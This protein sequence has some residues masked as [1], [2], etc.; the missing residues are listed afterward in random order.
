LL[1]AP[2]SRVSGGGAGGGGRLP[3]VEIV[4]LAR[5]L[6][7]GNRGIFSRALEAA[8][9][10][11]LDRGEQAMLFL[12]RRGS[13][14]FVLCRDC[15]HVPVCS[16]CQ[17]PYTVHQA[18]ERL[19]CHQC[20]RQRRMPGVCPLCGGARLRFFGLGTQR[21]EAEARTRFPS[22]RVAR[23]DRDAVRSAADH[24]EILDALARGEV[25]VVVGTQMLAKGHDLPNV[26]LVGVVSADI[27]LHM[28]D[29][30]SG[31]RAFQLLTQVA[32]RAGRGER[33]GRVVV[34]TYT[35]D[36]YAIRAAATHD[37]RAMFDAEM[38]VRR[39]AGY[40]PFGRLAR[41]L[42][43]HTNAAAAEE[44]AHRLATELRGLR[45]QRGLPGEAVIG[46]APAFHA[47]LRGRWRWQIIVRA[48]DPSAL[49]CGA[50]L[51]K[52]WTVDVD[53]VS[54]I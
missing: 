23:W 19:R 13:A 54:L 39:E 7:E 21:V 32:G 5:E 22:A 33:P 31:E 17:V 46:P 28:P 1:S 26:T 11:T 48:P 34:Q 44:E 15:G 24:A 49:L 37:Y 9:G 36:H 12:N 38:R 40:P 53:P 50:T 41:L 2:L 29:Y 52:G 45:L 51:R 16:G 3:S 47:R 20:N 27:A 43:S 42:Y 6:R 35:P 10:E 4:D 14:S 8:L 25:D 18:G 30:R